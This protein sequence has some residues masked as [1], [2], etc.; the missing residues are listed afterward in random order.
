MPP[1]EE[2]PANEKNQGGS[3]GYNGGASSEDEDN[4]SGSKIAYY[5]NLEE[6]D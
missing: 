6:L 5:T 2:K 3:A 4:N 1:L